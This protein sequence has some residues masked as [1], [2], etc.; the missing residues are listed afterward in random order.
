[1][2]R[3]RS[4]LSMRGTLLG[5]SF[6]PRPNSRV[7]YREHGYADGFINKRIFAREIKQFD[8]REQDCPVQKF[9]LRRLQRFDVIQAEPSCLLL[10]NPLSP[11]SD[12][13]QISPCAID[14]FVKQSGHENYGHDHTR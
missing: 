2:N 13:H 11:K 5:Y 1:M 10:F 6:E 7:C 14:A 3:V 12:Q 9:G 8:E 4:L